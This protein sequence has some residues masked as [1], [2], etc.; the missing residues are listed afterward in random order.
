MYTSISTWQKA[1]MKQLWPFVLFITSP[2]WV[3]T[4]RLQGTD[5][6]F[7][8]ADAVTQGA[9]Y[10]WRWS[11]HN[12]TTHSNISIIIKCKTVSLTHYGN[13]TVCHK[14]YYTI[15]KHCTNNACSHSSKLQSTGTNSRLPFTPRHSS[16]LFQPRRPRVHVSSRCVSCLSA[17]LLTVCPNGRWNECLQV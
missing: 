17:C 11:P 16:I 8:R 13:Y 9:Y 4:R 6:H 1:R 2:A 10:G 5:L 7:W 15:K 14:T 3:A 12:N